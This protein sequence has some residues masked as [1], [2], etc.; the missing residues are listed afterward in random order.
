MK[1]FIYIATCFIA[2][3]VSAGMSLPCPTT[4]NLQQ[5]TT[6]SDEIYRFEDFVYTDKIR[7]V[8]M[9]RSGWRLAPPVINL[10]DTASLI[11]EFD[12]LSGETPQYTYTLIHC[13]AD[14]KPSNLVNT[15]YLTGLAENEIRDYRFSRNTLL[16]YN[17]YRLALPNE[18]VQV[19]LPGNYLLYVY[20]EYDQEKP[21]L[22]RRF[23]IVEPLVQVTTDVHR[24]DNVRY[25]STSQEVDFTVRYGSL[26]PDD[27]RRNFR[28]TV[29]QNLNWATAITDLMP[30]F[31]NPGELVYDYEEENLFPGGS[32]F[33]H[34]DSKSL[35]YN[36]DRVRE[37]TFERPIRHIYLL[38]DQP[39]ARNTYE[40]QEDLNGK[41]LVKW[42]EAF[43][44]DTEADYVMVHF[45]LMTGE[46]IEDTDVFVYGALTGWR[47]GDENRC[48]FNPATGAYEINLLLKQGYYNYAWATLPRGQVKPGLT[49]IDGNH[50]ETENEYYVFVYYRDIRERFDR[51]VGV[52]TT[53]SVKMPRAAR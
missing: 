15:E 33:L 16:N 51:L 21:V 2:L 19:K 1:I 7:T 14:W 3:P 9:Y 28:V 27:P 18:D 42:D 35:R 52:Q 30:K 36:S 22:T 12:D 24:T 8:E 39:K 26:Q 25:I 5:I 6:G 45:Q 40:F 31:I 41:Y 37:I 10:R 11:L 46:P 49:E 47:A 48:A 17:H 44:S 38:P 4:T 32:E 29:C 23:F 53:G 50:F 20:R 43:D 13:T 34:F